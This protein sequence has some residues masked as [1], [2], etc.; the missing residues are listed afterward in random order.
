LVRSG[1]ENEPSR[2]RRR[3]LSGGSLARPAFALTSLLFPLSYPL[4]HLRFV[5]FASFAPRIFWVR[6]IQLSVSF[7]RDR[8]RP[9]RQES[10]PQPRA[11]FEARYCGRLSS[12]IRPA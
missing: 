5:S 4:R 7:G 6:G 12:R 2:Y 3:V 10:E 8:S 11:F 9:M 1:A